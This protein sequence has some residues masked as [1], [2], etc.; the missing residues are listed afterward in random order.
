M[1]CPV[2]CSSHPHCPDGFTSKNTYSSEVVS[3]KSNAPNARPRICIMRRQRP[4]I[5]AGT[6]WIEYPISADGN[7]RQSTMP[8]GGGGAETRRGPNKQV[9]GTVFPQEAFFVE[10]PCREQGAA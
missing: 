1:G 4:T 5:S 3:A 7:A 10:S 6:G 2:K 9:P 8:G